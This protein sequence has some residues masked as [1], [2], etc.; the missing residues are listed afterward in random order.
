MPFGIVTFAK[1]VSTPVVSVTFAAISIV[2]LTLYVIFCTGRKS[3]TNGWV[4]SKI[5]V[6]VSVLLTLLLVSLTVALR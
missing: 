1:T 6:L 2:W 4:L 5:I 3:N